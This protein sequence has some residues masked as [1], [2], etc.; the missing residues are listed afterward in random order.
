[1]LSAISLT[2]VVIPWRPCRR[3]G[4][5]HGETRQPRRQKVAAPGL[6]QPRPSYPADHGK[7]AAK[8]PMP[9]LL[10]L[11]LSQVIGS[12]A[13]EMPTGLIIRR[14]VGSIPTCPTVRMIPRDLR[15]SASSAGRDGDV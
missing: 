15:F 11:V 4:L 14:S 8:S 13:T 6:V 9:P 10:A 12:E 2:T 5:I 7:C 1:M 3:G